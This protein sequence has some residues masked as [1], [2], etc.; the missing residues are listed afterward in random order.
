MIIEKLLPQ[1]LEDEI[2]KT[3][4]SPAFWWQWNAENIIAT[5]PD[6]YVSQMTHVFFYGGVVRSRSFALVNTV[7]GYFLEKTKFK[8]KRIVRIKANL[9]HNLVHNEQ[10]LIN[11]NHTDL[12]THAKGNYVSIVYYVDNSDGDTVVYEEDRETIKLSVPPIK[13]KCVWFDAKNTWHRSN[14][15]TH[16]K[17][18]V[19][20]NFV[21]EVE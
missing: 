2:Q 13:G 11:L 15:P 16:H 14:I 8:L 17:R 7:L 4:M 12:E 19:V 18:R 3:I 20:I 9:I 6:E 21:L 1:E 10:S 5:T